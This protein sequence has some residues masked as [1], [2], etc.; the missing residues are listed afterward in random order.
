[1][2]TPNSVDEDAANN[3]NFSA[4]GTTVN[5]PSNFLW[6]EIEKNLKTPLFTILYKCI[7]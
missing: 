3:A 1:M 5:K 6:Q 4:T 7:T 2:L